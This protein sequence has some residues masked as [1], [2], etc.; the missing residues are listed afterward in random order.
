ML[1]LSALVAV[2]SLA[3]TLSSSTVPAQTH[4]ER[5]EFTA[6]AIVNDNLGAGMGRVIMR[7]TRWSTEAERGLLTRTLL[8]SGPSD[9]LDVLQ[10][11]KSVGTIRTPDSLGYDLR[12]AHQEPSEDGG[13][14][15]VI[16]TDRPMSF[17]EAAN[18]PRTVDY[19]FTVIQMQLDKNG[20]GKGTMSY[21]TKIIARGN[22]IELENF[23]SAPVMLTEV[24]SKK[25]D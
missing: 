11:Q 6:N 19:P 24:R 5:E 1:K 2:A 23:S 13:R 10:D 22:T 20:E 3:V 16:A 21:A 12:Y 14:R 17:W 25:L 9:L 18:R 15:V 8:K 4:G 7:V